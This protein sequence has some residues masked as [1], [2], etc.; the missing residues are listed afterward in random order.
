MGVTLGTIALVLVLLV[1]EVLSPDVLLMGAL[2]FL[3]AV[4]IVPLREGLSG[5]AEPTLLAL[6]SLFVVAAGLRS[7]GILR[8]AAEL[9]FG[10][11]ERLRP[12]LLRLVV[13][14]GVSSAFLNNTPIVAMGI[15]SVLSWTRSRP[16]HPSK[17]LIP[18]SYASILG[19][20]CTLM[21]TSTNLVADGLLRQ[22]G[23]PG[24]GFFELAMLGIPLALVG[25][26]YLVLVSPRLLPHE[27]ELEVEGGGGRS[28]A[29]GVQ[30]L[31]VGPSSRCEG[32]TV[33]ELGLNPPKVALIRL[34]RESGTVIHPSPGTRILEGDRMIFRADPGALE[35]LEERLGL[36][37]MEISEGEDEEEGPLELREAV[38]PEGSVLEGERVSDVNFPGRYGARVV[39]VIRHG[40]ELADDPGSAVLRA[41]DTLYLAG[42][43]GFTEAFQE[44]RDFYLMGEEALPRKRSQVSLRRPT[45]AKA[46]LLIL[47]AVVA[48]ATSR[49]LHISLAAL[50]GAVAM[51]AFKLVTPAEARRSID[52]SVLMIIGAAIG[53]GRALEIS[54]AARW[55]GEGIVA[56]GAPLGGVGIL[57]AILAACML[58]T[59]TITNNAAVALIFPVAVSAA[60]SQGLEARPFVV[61]ITVG[62]SLA[63]ATPLGY[64]TNLMVFGPGRY[65]F[66]DFLRVGLPLQLILA[67][68]SIIL[69]PLIWPLN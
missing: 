24:L 23:Y 40:V 1:R 2:G 48:L 6:G 65:R 63:F 42:A 7:T 53:L 18:L 35:E 22:E 39:A 30:V 10:G 56:L 26:A 21:G 15:S 29:Y 62:A 32:G 50:L 27:T 13:A 59:L 11:F 64:Q 55:I 36:D 8:K 61:A 43:P 54:G 46:G 9:L 52:W 57:A 37:R 49:L 66:G 4:G 41:G 14:S 69:I 28:P 33:E 34:V 38:I 16:I 47:A 45:E 58:F 5:F 25:F 60:A 67:L 51:V 31:Q 20:I 3:M 12:V 44:G 17:L 19:G 68:L